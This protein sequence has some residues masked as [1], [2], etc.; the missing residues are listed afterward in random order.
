MLFMRIN[1][2]NQ[3]RAKYM[4]HSPRKTDSELCFRSTVEKTRTSSISKAR[5]GSQYFNMQG[6]GNPVGI[7]DIRPFGAPVTPGTIYKN[8]EDGCQ[9]L[10]HK[11]R[12]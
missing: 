11:L 3:T 5:R 7:E 8:Q 9:L 1:R 2:S 6:N 4:D 12:L 10:K